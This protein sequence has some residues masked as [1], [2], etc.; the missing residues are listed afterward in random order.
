MKLRHNMP[1][2]EEME[3]FGQCEWQLGDK[4]GMEL[5]ESIPNSY[6]DHGLVNF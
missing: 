3:S 1:I 4:F 2:T 6:E 5:I